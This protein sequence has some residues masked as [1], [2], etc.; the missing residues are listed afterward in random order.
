M[1]VLADA[2]IV[3][4]R[5][6]AS[7]KEGDDVSIA[8]IRADGL[9]HSIL[10]K[11][12]SAQYRAFLSGTRN[13]RK[14]LYPAYKANRKDMVPPKHLYATKEHL[15][16]Q[17]NAE[18]S[19]GCEA[20]DSIGVAHTE[21]GGDCIIASIDKDFHQL[22][23]SF[24]NFVKD[25]KYFIDETEGKRF[26]WKQVMLGDKSDNVP[27]FDGMAR[28][29]PTKFIQAVWND[30]DALD[31]EYDMFNWVLENYSSYEDLKLN[32]SLLWIWREEG[33]G[34]VEPEPQ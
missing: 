20:D 32:A 34:W 13:W 10:E 11:T 18:L 8:C 14:E 24:Y 23:G 28:V 3:A 9:M 16:S 30:I 1:L 17:W 27:G 2:D 33:V 5:A 19:D 22:G 29:K 25:E 26:F 12:G 15:I 4:Y 7:C 31:D 21:T 6:S